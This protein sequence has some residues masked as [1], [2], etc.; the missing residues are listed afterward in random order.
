MW[1]I[2]IIH[3][4]ELSTW[5][6][7]LER[8]V[9]SCLIWESSVISVSWDQVC[10]CLISANPTSWP[11]CSVEQWILNRREEGGHSD[12]LVH[13]GDPGGLAWSCLC[14]SLPYGVTVDSILHSPS[15]QYYKSRFPGGLQRIFQGGQSA[16]QGLVRLRWCL[17]WISRVTVLRA[18]YFGLAVL[19]GFSDLGRLLP[20]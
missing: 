19:Q 2:E 20:S 10:S 7:K 14:F 4:S 18:G 16:S 17:A 9:W 5:G 13:R 1:V 3:S 11:Q 8:R 6:N 12:F 15:N